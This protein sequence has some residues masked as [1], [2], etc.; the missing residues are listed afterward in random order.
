MQ[1]VLL[2]ICSIRNS[3]WWCSINQRRSPNALF[4]SFTPPK[5]QAEILKCV[6]TW[7]FLS[8][9]KLNWDLF[10][11]V[12]VGYSCSHRLGWISRSDEGS[13]SWF[14]TNSWNCGHRSWCSFRS[15]RH[16]HRFNEP[17]GIA[18]PNSKLIMQFLLIFIS[19]YIFLNINLV[20]SWWRSRWNELCWLSDPY[21]SSHQRNCSLL[22]RYGKVVPLYTLIKKNNNK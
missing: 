7:F 8:A 20:V 3:K 15:S 13:P 4:N 19:L 6:Q 12:F 9:L 10:V 17:N 1:R 21:G 14:A 11:S 5:K 2:L 22:P 18:S 16:N